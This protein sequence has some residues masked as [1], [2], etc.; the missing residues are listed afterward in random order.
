[1]RMR[2]PV[3]ERRTEQQLRFEKSIDFIAETGAARQD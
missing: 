2:V 3:P 1:M